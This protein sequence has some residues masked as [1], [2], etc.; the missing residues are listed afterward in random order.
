MSKL[1]KPSKSNEIISDK[2]KLNRIARNIENVEANI[3]GFSLFYQNVKAIVEDY[4]YM[5]GK[6]V[7]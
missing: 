2:E 4:I 1:T 6:H 5:G 3:T 7:D